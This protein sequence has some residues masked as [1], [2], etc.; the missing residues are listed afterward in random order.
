[1][2]ILSDVSANAFKNAVCAVSTRKKGILYEHDWGWVG[3]CARKNTSMMAC[4]SITIIYRLHA[5]LLTC[6]H[7]DAYVISNTDMYC[8]QYLCVISHVSYMNIPIQQHKTYQGVVVVVVVVRV[9][10]CE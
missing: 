4:T 2:T 8:F 5:D 1:M 9:C 7:V 10:M 3:W 6:T